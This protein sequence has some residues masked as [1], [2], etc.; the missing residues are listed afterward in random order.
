MCVETY[1]GW[2]SCEPGPVGPWAS[3]PRRLPFGA[4]MAAHSNHSLLEDQALKYLVTCLFPLLDCES[5][6]G[7]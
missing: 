5:R 3:A 2:A 4:H 6:R 1:D 7:H